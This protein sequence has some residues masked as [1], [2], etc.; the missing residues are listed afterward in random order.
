MG[1]L[2]EVVIVDYLRSAFS[3]SRPKEPEKDILNNWRADDLGAELIKAIVKRTGIKAE[4][5]DE[6]IVGS[7]RAIG[8]QATFGGRFIHFLAELP[9]SVASHFVDRQCGSSMT[10]IHN[11]AME[12]MCGFSDVVM[13]VGIEHMTHLPI[14]DVGTAINPRFMSDPKFKNVEIQV[15][16]NMGFTAEKL[17]RFGKISREDMDKWALRSHQRAAKAVQEGYY[18]GEIMPV[19]GQLPDGKKV[20]VDVDQSIR[21]DTTLEQLAQ[22][23]PA[24]MAD[25]VITAGNSSPLNAGATAMMI[26]SREKAKQLGLKPLASIVSMGWAGVEP[27]MMGMGP[28]PAARKALKAVGLG[29]KDIDFWEINEAFSVVPLYAIKELGIDPEKVNIKGGALALGHPLGASGNRLVGTLARI[30]SMEGG[31]YGLAT[32][33]VGGGQGVATI[34][35]REK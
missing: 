30:L 13:S 21:A 8:E 29:V 14:T 16:M 33:C 12:I 28:V 11:G 17:G 4:V 9:N 1:Q 2:R 25:G 35:K 6:L 27:S 34:I 31:T 3:R 18:K 15:T 22:L 20:M 23:K 32:P 10:T 26:M 5:I 24:Y 7:A 19:E